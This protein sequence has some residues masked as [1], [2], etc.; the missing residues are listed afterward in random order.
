MG[1]RRV[2][3]GTNDPN[4]GHVCGR[5]LGI[6]FYLKTGELFIA[7]AYRGLFVSS[8]DGRV[9]TTVATSAEGQTFK[10]VD[11][12]D[13]DQLS[14][15]VYFTDASSRF[16]LSQIPEA[17][18]AGDE[19]GRLLKYNPSTKEVTVLLKQ[20]AGAAGVALSADGKYALVTEFLA[21]RIRKF[22]LQGPK[23]NTSEVVV[24]LEGRPDKIRSTYFG[25]FWVAM[26]VQNSTET[27]NVPKAVKINGDGEILETLNF[28]KY[29]GSTMISEFNQ[30]ASRFYVGSMEADFLGVLYS[31]LG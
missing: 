23:A 14:G 25:N 15:H 28:D 26:N 30:R 8:P 2:C 12:V 31:S 4:L 10:L 22:W 18:V 5:P 24:T 29:Y 3:D 27:P 16:S 1:S 20:L 21:K 11:G 6:R 13:V 9:T 19:T 17:I 7:D